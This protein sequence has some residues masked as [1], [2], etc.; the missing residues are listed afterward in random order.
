MEKKPS[1]LYSLILTIALMLF[2]LSASIAA[3]LLCRPF[4][5]AHIGWLDLTART[6][7]SESVIREAY[8]DMMDFCVFGEEFDTGELAWSE[9][10]KQHFADCAVLF[11]L[12]FTVLI[13]SS[14]ILLLCFAFYLKQRANAR[15]GRTQ[16]TALRLAGH[17][18]AFWAGTILIAVFLIIAALC[19]VDFDRAFVTFH[20][21]F[22][23]GKTNWLFDP[24]VDEIIK[25]L[26]EVFFRNCA[27]LIVGL[28]F[29]GCLILIIADRFRGAR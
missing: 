21:L 10:G 5:Y 6:G 22:F 29:A 24:A 19:A 20:H 26:P 15:A 28:L 23:P 17:G 3:P 9:D 1:I 14:A 16:I 4:F 11:R 13:I 7:Y 27:I 8:D 25:I 12:D 18:P 2:V